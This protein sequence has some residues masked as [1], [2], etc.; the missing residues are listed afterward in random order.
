MQANER[1]EMIRPLQDRLSNPLHL[2]FVLRLHRD[3][4]ALGHPL[5]GSVEHLISGWRGEFANLAE[6]Q[7]WLERMLGGLPSPTHPPRSKE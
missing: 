2:A 7:A 5:C 6:L 4:D 3:C 1:R